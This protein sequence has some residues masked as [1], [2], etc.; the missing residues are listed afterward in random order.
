[1]QAERD[2]AS[3]TAEALYKDSKNT[4]AALNEESAHKY[5]ALDR[6]RLNEQNESRRRTETVIDD[7]KRDMDNLKSHSER[8]TEQ[9]L[10]KDGDS[11]KRRAEENAK[12]QRESG[13]NQTREL[14]AQVRDLLSSE[15]LYMKERG[16]GKVDAVRE[17]EDENRAQARRVDEA[18][19][20]EVKKLQIQAEA[21]DSH[22]TENAESNLHERDT[23]FTN[24]LAKKAA[25]SRE[26]Q[27]AISQRYEAAFKEA[28]I[29]G[30]KERQYAQDRI[31]QTSRNASEDRATALQNQALVYQKN[32][33]TQRQLDKD[34]VSILQKELNQ[35]NAP[36]EETDISPAV[37][38]V[39][40]RS[41]VKQYEKSLNAEI[42][43]N[44]R[45]NDAIKRTSA[46]RFQTVE[47]EHKSQL[48]M[49]NMAHQAEKHQNEARFI[50]HV[51]DTEASK[52]QV[53]RT[54]HQDNER[55]LEIMARA[56]SQS[57][58][59]QRNDYDVIVQTL[60]DDAS[61]RV[62]TVRQEAEFAMK[63]QH[64]ATAVRENELIR[65]YEKKLADQKTEY[66]TR[67]DDVK[68]EAAQKLRELER[69]DKQIYD[70][71]GR[72]YD[73]RI[74]QLEA[75]Q[76]ERE[77]I[78]TQN[79]EDQLDKVKRSNALLQSKKG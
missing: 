25:E 76:K 72:A 21:V 2:S 52:N 55:E 40:R 46:E 77:R 49:Q 62:N 75:Q 71:Q 26:D 18:H 60:R 7:A 69:R 42:E 17:Y 43:R 37:E 68:I 66:E 56:Y 65:G 9:R 67:L 51:T 5:V 12:A 27:Q 57:T 29:R 39:V 19:A 32:I 44:Q 11:A 1:M 23:Y 48:T 30:R 47:S 74:S 64:R 6:E 10:T 63:T 16:Q 31:E 59:R 58:Q 45:A 20:Q 28:E 13:T 3:R 54:A 22:N 70:D 14:R 34:A 15:N 50:D 36:A 38:N 78:V 53:L 61:S 73:Q 79:F 24:L 4:I 35:K 8:A 41:I 33:E